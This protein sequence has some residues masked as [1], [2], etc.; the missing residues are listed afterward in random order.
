MPRP[1]HILLA[2]ALLS[3]LWAAALLVAA[4]ATGDPGQEYRARAAAMS[5][6]Q[7][8]RERQALTNEIRTLEEHRAELPPAPQEAPQAGQDTTRAYLDQHLEQARQK[9]RHVNALLAEGGHAVHEIRYKVVPR[10]PVAAAPE[11][12]EAAPAEPEKAAAPTP[13]DTE[14]P[15][16]PDTPANPRK[17]A[18]A[19]PAA[20]TAPSATPPSPAA[21]VAPAAPAPAATVTAVTWA[22]Q[23]EGLVVRVAVPGPGAPRCR[24]F[25]LDGPPRVVLD[26]LDAGAPPAALPE[27]LAVGG[28]LAERIRTGWHPEAGFVRVVLDLPRG[29]L[30][31]SLDT[32]P[33]RAE[34]TLRP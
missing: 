6:P 17:A 1:R 12:P 23:G 24:V 26:V 11:T 3:G 31:H 9:L 29:G 4:C 7:L 5:G 33:G 2:A 27:A 8:L 22:A 15:D 28:P 18:A 10:P 32:A 16:R 21:P 13:P 30:R 34:L 19:Q 14:Q 20:P 25:T